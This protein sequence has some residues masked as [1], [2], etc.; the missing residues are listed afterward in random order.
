M[1]ITLQLIRLL[2]VLVIAFAYAIFDV[3][4]KRNVPNVFVYSALGASI[5][6][7]LTYGYSGIAVNFL[8]AL[9]I[10]GAGYV[11]YRAGLWGAGDFFELAT[12]SLI[13]PIQPAPYLSAL[14]QFGMPFILSVFIFT[15]L[16]AVWMV[17]IYYLLIKKRPKVRG[18]IDELNLTAAFVLLALYIVLYAFTFLL[19]GF[20]WNRLILILA[21]S[22]PSSIMLVYEQRITNN[23]TRWVYPKQLEDGDIIAMNMMD[24]KEIAYFKKKDRQFGR[25]AT[26]ELIAR[27][28]NVRKKL[29]VYKDAAPLAFFIFIGVVLSLLLGNIIL[30][31]IY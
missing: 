13:I 1:F 25:L 18:G 22:I 8:L 19:F 30:Y 5:L 12:I 24:K 29:P 28:R 20:S 17:P 9:I 23:M 26:K 15:G 7:A 10:G 4:N 3:F 11:I 2:A 21:V 27:F 6:L 31:V 16:A 14:S